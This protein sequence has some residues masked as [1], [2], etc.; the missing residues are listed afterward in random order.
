[1]FTLAEYFSQKSV[2]KFKK[3]HF[4]KI[5]SKETVEKSN[6]SVDSK[7]PQNKNCLKIIVAP[8]EP[9]KTTKTELKT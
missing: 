5:K 7:I 6:K 8:P 4:F 2:K 3:R 9:R 1:M